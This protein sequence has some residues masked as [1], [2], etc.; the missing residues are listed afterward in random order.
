MTDLVADLRLLREEVSS[1]VKTIP[2][3]VASVS[4][5]VGECVL[6]IAWD[7]SGTAPAELSVPSAPAEPDDMI[8]DGI[9]TVVAPLVGTFYVA[10]EPDAPP[11][12]RPGERVKAGQTVGIVEAM[13]LMNR[14]NSEWSGEVVEVA[15][16]D[17]QPVEFEQVLIK[18]R[19]DQP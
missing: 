18:I 9:R 4:L 2:G 5:R 10:S 17:G 8:D 6:E 15:V 1:L 12:V 13:K 7:H 16:G 3:P 19:A 14:V 11:F